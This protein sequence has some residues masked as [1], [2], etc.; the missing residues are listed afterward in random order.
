MATRIGTAFVD[1]KGDFTQLNQGVAAALAPTKLG[2]YGKAAGIAAGAAFAGG[3][4]AAGLTKLAYDIGSEFDTAFDKIRVG[5]GKT[6]KPLKKLEK[7]FKA[8]FASVPTDAGTAADAIAGLNRRLGLTGKPLRR[9]AKDMLELSRLTDS[10]L[11]GNIQSVTRLFGDWSVKT[12]KQAYR[13][14]ELYRAG[15]KSGIAVKELADYMVQFGS[16]LRSLGFSFDEAAAMFSRFEKEGVNIQTSMPGLRMALKNFAEDGKEPVKALQAT[17]REMKRL[18]P[19]AESTALAFETFGV[20]AGTD[21]ARAVSEGRFEFKDFIKEMKGGHDTIQRSAKDTND[22]GENMKVFGNKLKVAVEPAAT[23]VFNALGGISKILASPKTDKALKNFKQIFNTTFGFVYRQV[24]KPFVTLVRES[25]KAIRTVVQNVS[26]FVNG[27]VKDMWEKVRDKFQSGVKAVKGFVKDLRTGVKSG[28]SAVR[29]GMVNVFTGAWDKIEGIFEGGAN[30][31]IG[32]VNK[33]IDA[34]N[35]IP[36]VPDIGKIDTIGSSGPKTP[37][38]KTFK[39]FQRGSLITGGKPSGDSVPALLERGEYV[40]NRE[41]VKK[42]GVQN[43]DHLNF[44]KA[45]RFQTG[46]PVRLIGGGIA[47]AVSGAAG[48][49]ADVVGDI[50]GASA[51]Y[52][53]NKLPKPNIPEPF[54]GT[55]PYM[56]KAATEYIKKKVREM[57][58]VGGGSSSYSGPPADFSD[59]GNNAYVD[60]HTL[61]VAA[62]LMDKFG[63]SINSSYRTPEHNAA[64]GGV[65]GSLHTHGSMSNPGAIDFGP[66]STAMQTWVGQHI[67]GVQENLIHDVGSGLHNHIGFFQRGG[68]AGGLRRMVK[69]GAVVKQAA[70]LLARKG[71]DFKAIAGILGNAWRESMGWNTEQMELTGLDNGGLFGFTTSPVSMPDLRNY[72]A[73]KGKSWA[74]VD[75]QINFMLSHGQPTGM[76]LRGALNAKDSIPDTTEL[77]MDEWER[78]GVPAL[79]ERIKGGFMAA[80]IMKDLPLGGGVEGKAFGGSGKAGFGYAIGDPNPAAVERSHKKTLGKIKTKGLSYLFKDKLTGMGGILASLGERLDISE[81]NAS[82]EWGPGGSE[83]TDAE[84]A[85]QV[86][87]NKRILHEQTTESR[88]LNEAIAGLYAKETAMTDAMWAAKPKGSKTHWKFAALKKAVKDIRGNINA[89]GDNRETL[90]GTTGLGGEMFDTQM[91]LKNLG[92]ASTVES[93]SAAARD[94]ELVS[95]MRE[96]LGLANRNNAILSAQLPIYQQFMPK[97]HDGGIYNAP[98]GQTEGPA[99]L[100]DGELVLTPEQQAAGGN[101]INLWVNGVKADPSQVRMEVERNT[102]SFA[103][104]A[105]TGNHGPKFSTAGLR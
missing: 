88:W 16:P 46:G 51:S 5:T 53:L 60:S 31:V 75:T 47:D 36:G 86:D 63:V 35:A 67:A 91:R 2:K 84:K 34:I 44:K 100:R 11:A 101:T 52:F 20:R 14:N 94:S 69:G 76:A 50:S 43:L 96:Q 95:L 18:G 66:P 81:Q 58:P 59:L 24:L 49:A 89:L 74:D 82:A 87:L 99:L 10:D 54:T 37:A 79:S 55:G 85:E 23:A 39:G 19:G 42:V 45:A 64:V 68:L 25:F 78:P 33:I 104:K 73:S 22:F 72:A 56:I 105:R 40:L 97:F 17:F 4:A 83:M 61:A 32:V 98:V 29:D 92:V 6:G 80:R 28:I 90:V 65:P 9:L 93:S 102:A 77:F 57:L 62:Y 21:L 26:K 70:P 12:D 71:F 103:R 41:A 15:Q 27:D 1:V 8:V 13:L 48:A 7:D 30:A 3:V 38:Q